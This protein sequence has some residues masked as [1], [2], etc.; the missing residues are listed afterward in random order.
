MILGKQNP[1]VTAHEVSAR[2]RDILALLPVTSSNSVALELMRFFDELLKA[3]GG[4]EICN[5]LL[6]SIDVPT[7]EPSLLMVILMCTHLQRGILGQRQAFLERV[8]E[9][10]EAEWG[11][12]RTRAL[13]DDFR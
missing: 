7:F 3:P 2:F 9:R 5:E 13:L 1:P 11:T 4:V 6:P 10:F 12:C 8:V